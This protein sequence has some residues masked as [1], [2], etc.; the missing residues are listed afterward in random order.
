MTG[1]A[2][3]LEL[4]YLGLEVSDL[5]RWR[6]FAVQAMGLVDAAQPATSGGGLRLRMDEAPWRLLLTQGPA[7]DCA[8]A[9]WRVADAT[10]LQAFCAHLDRLGHPWSVGTAD[11]CRWRGAQAMVH[12]QDPG[13]CRHEAYCADPALPAA[14]F[15]SPVVPRGFVTGAGGLGHIVYEVA[16]IAAQQRFATEVLGLRLSDTIVFEPVPRVNVEVSFYHANPRHHSYAIAPRPPRPGPAKSVH[17]LMLEVHDITDVGLA[18]DR[19]LAAG[20]PITMDIGQ[21]PND[22]MVSFYVQTP[23]GF[24]VEFGC[25]GVLV[26]DA[27]WQPERYR[28]ISLWGHRPAPSPAAG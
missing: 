23:S 10:A 3:L 6:D 9:G 4:G 24:H 11:E 25:G 28:G 13:G 7:D 27:R 26:D 2:G 18:R 8:H 5:S 15:H 14:R 16:D 20:H 1:G 21:H 19:C 22:R 12:F 17:H